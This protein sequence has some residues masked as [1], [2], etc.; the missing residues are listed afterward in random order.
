MDAA[1][2]ELLDEGESED[3]VA[4]IIR[5]G[6]PGVAPP[7]VRLVAEFG[8]I[9]T[10]RV[11]R[12]EIIKT[13]E[14]ETVASFKA[15]RIFGPEP[16][17]DDELLE[18][19]SESF[20]FVDE[21]RPPEETATGR[22]CLIGVVDWGCD[23]AHPDFR[24]PDGTTR[25]LALWDQRPQTNRT[26]PVPYGYGVVHAREAIN[27]AL[28][29]S[30]PY[31]TLGYH[32]ADSD[33]GQGSHGTHV[34]GIAAGNG[35]AG[36][37][38]GVAPEAD[39]VF[40]HSS[41]LASE[42]PDRLGDSVTLL[43]AIDFIKGAA[44]DRPWVINLSMGRHGEPHDGTTLV[45][46]GLD[47]IL[48]AAPGRAIVQSTGN[49]FDRRIHSSGQLRPADERQL[50]WEVAEIDPTPNQLEVWYSGLD[51]FEVE[52]IGPDECLR[53][54]AALEAQTAFMLN[55]VE[56]GKIYHRR[57]EPNNLSN[58]I[59]IFLHRGAPAGEWIVTIKGKDVVDGRY[60]AWIERDAACPRCQSN[61]SAKDAVSISTT[62]T[63]CNGFRTIA[64]G[65]YNLHSPRRELA[66]FSSS[67]P[68]RDGRLKPDLV[69]PGVRVLAA[70][71]APR[72]AD[73]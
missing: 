12:G 3:E 13:R 43:E 22:R 63:I 45:E 36:G 5:L 23:F 52:V 55:G 61:F 25:L 35:R 34:L 48:R 68:T 19:I 59:E 8:H 73:G 70:R 39:L 50:V 67:G 62:G 66:P 38:P 28:K 4:A 11:K 60:H 7:G 42:G 16:E 30:D 47:Q 54:R 33:T 65:A 1:L 69:A 15:P 49:Y 10:C 51:T 37:P 26:V 18:D 32:P 53:Q 29:T 17:P 2:W 46:Q 6:Q 24:H 9:A 44:E 27:H 57:A 58:H 40:V 21:R 41:T 72:A 64:V 56:V 14:A 71:S 20:T 31:A